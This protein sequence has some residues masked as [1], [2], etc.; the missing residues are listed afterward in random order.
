MSGPYC[1]TCRHYA[2]APLSDRIYAECMDPTKL[3]YYGKGDAKNNH[4]EV[5]EGDTCQN[6][7]ASVM[8]LRSEVARFIY[9][10]EQ[11][12]RKVSAIPFTCQEW[13]QISDEALRYREPT[14]P[15]KPARNE[16]M[17]C[18]VEIVADARELRAAV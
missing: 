8:A 16:F 5:N 12:V 17:G 6:W 14:D 2:P 15:T 18:L 11:L 7:S 9:R 4:P 13:E 1:K 10:H 3:I